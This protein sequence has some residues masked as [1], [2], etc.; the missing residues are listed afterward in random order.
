ML[1]T[2]LLTAWALV[3]VLVVPTITTA[4]PPSPPP[5]FAI[6]NVRVVTGTG[7]TLES[8]TVLIADGLIEAVGTGVATPADAW[9]IDGTDLTLYPGLIDAM[10][11]LGIKKEEESDGDGGNPFAGAMSHL[12][13]ED[14]PLTTPW[15][16]AAD[17]IDAG[18]FGEGGKAAK[19]REAGFTSVVATPEEGIFAGQAAVVN[20]GQLGAEDYVRSQ[21]VAPNVAHRIGFQQQSFGSFPSS[22]MGVIAY[23]R[24]IMED[25]DHYA[26]TKAAYAVSPRGMT[27]PTYDRT[28]EPVEA[29]RE[30]GRP[31]LLPA[32]LPRQIDRAMLLAGEY[33][34]NAI[35]Y[36]AHG[37]YQRVDELS[38]AGTPV[39]LSLDWPDEGTDV[40]PEADIPIRTVYHRRMAPASAAKLAEAGVP[41]AFYSAGLGSASDVF[42]GVRAAIEAGLS[43]DDALAA[44][45]SGPAAIYGVDAQLGTIEA[46]KIA[47][48]VLA[49]DWPWAEDAEIAAVFVDGVKFQ[50]RETEEEDLD[51][52]AQDV[53]GTW[54]FTLVTPQGSQE[55]TGTLEMDEEG[56]VTG[57][58]VGD[59]TSTVEDGRM[60]GTMLRFKTTREMAG[61]TINPGFTAEVS[62]ETL[63][64][65]VTVG[66]FGM[67]VKAER[68][69]K[70][71]ETT[72]DAESED[73]EG[74]A[75]A[76]TAEELE[77]V[78][79]VFAAP[80][81]EMDDFVITNAT[82]WTLAGED[83]PDDDA[84]EIIENGHVVV[85]DGKIA[86]VGE[87]A[88]PSSGTVID[89]QGGHLIPG[90]FD[91]HSHIAI[92]GGGN[93]GSTAVSSMV[94]IGDVINPDDINIYRALA[95]GVTTANI[96]HGSSNPIG[97]KNQ[98]IKLRWGS[99]AET[100]KFEGAMP[101]IKF[102]LGE[103]P[104]RSNFRGFGIPQRYPQTRMGVMDVIRRAFTEARGYQQEWDAW[105]AAGRS[106]VAPR[107]DL[108][109]EALVEIMEGERL[110]HSHCYRADEILQLLRLA[111]EFGFQ[112][113]TLQHVLEGYKV[114]DEI[115]EHGAGASTFS[116]WWGY[117]VEAYDA[118]PHNAALMTERGV[119]VS[120]N[121]DSGEEMRHLN[122][123]AAKAIKWGGMSEVEALK[124]VTLNPAKQFRID[125]RIGSIEVGKDADLALYNANPMSVFSVV[126]K[127]WIDG[128][129]YFDLEADRE[130]QAKI[131]ALKA[132][133]NPP[134]EE[135]SEEAPEAAGVP[136]G[137]TAA[138]TT[139]LWTE[140]TYTCRHEVNR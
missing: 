20:L 117:K 19:W 125:D 100:M 58:L 12:E 121:S 55:F 57:E 39:L 112:I 15:H 110:V 14:R 97:G 44:M 105:E 31:F 92:E 123:E 29:A 122:Q 88:G 107:R 74:E 84:T 24:Q 103:N 10:T 109:M 118:I 34:L 47:N 38:E 139:T 134:D 59:Q 68:T 131:D 49:T 45:T 32:D 61:Q 90:I 37:A 93:E 62:G 6:E 72:A 26:A 94:G 127:T 36:G 8:A 101:G 78:M 106:G 82:I 46:G 17:E 66:S 65:T 130:R 27:R 104:K 113:A 41:F 33:D 136:A 64:G 120:I 2:R 96:L 95:G 138:T 25:T 21:V 81:E 108:Q 98:V 11:P 79:A 111:E 3:A 48:L 129:L 56:K 69:A 53:S 126:Q 18:A 23:V 13:P 89:A 70:P 52:P 30:A 28:L 119:L 140:P 128:D 133:L 115:A 51:P 9:V 114:A 124:L 137:R 63:A 67:D 132:K 16:S 86:S 50:E 5:F 35:I 77:E 80:A 75:V 116:D 87:G 85:A 43:D 83:G 1:R 4:E 40:D 135:D 71:A 76:V 60:S 102:A 7:E 91:A 42:K 22:L 73:E 99:D 54:A